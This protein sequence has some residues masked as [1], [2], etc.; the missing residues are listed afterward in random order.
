[1]PSSYLEEFVLGAK[2]LEIFSRRYEF[3]QCWK[4]SRTYLISNQSLSEAYSDENDHAYGNGNSNGITNPKLSLDS[5]YPP[6]PDE[7]TQFD[8]K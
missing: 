6:V 1:M 7:L 5:Q 4:T 3:R 2:Y 8:S